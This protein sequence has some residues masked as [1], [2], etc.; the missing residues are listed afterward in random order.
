MSSI[1]VQLKGL[2]AKV[3]AGEVNQL[4]AGSASSGSNPAATSTPEQQQQQDELFDSKW[5]Q[6]GS[7]RNSSTS[8]SSI[9]GGG[10]SSNNG[11]NNSFDEKRKK[12]VSFSGL[13]SE[14]GGSSGNNSRSIARELETGRGG[15]AA[16]GAEAGPADE[17][18]SSWLRISQKVRSASPSFNIFKNTDN[19]VWDCDCTHALLWNI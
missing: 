8:S 6:V 13:M 3:L 4:A 19:F 17:E 2:L 9:T 11:T 1:V 16:S 10:F 14:S 5:E 7:M 15:D 12:S 18:D